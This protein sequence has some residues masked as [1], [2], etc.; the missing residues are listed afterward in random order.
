MPI[1]CEIITQE[2][3]VF[4]DDVDIVIA[5]SVEGEMGIL[6]NHSPMIV[7]L[8]YGE[9]RTRKGNITEAFAIG[10]GVLQVTGERVIVLADS[11]E[12]AEEIDI[13]RAQAARE[14]A[15]RL[16]EE[17]VPED[18]AAYAQ[19]EAAIRRAE[20]RI[21]VARRV[22]GRRGTGPGA[23]EFGRPEPSESE[24]SGA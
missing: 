20:V 4:D 22:G 12:E 13:A 1:H 7:A 23:M 3:K 15:A 10:G 11:A 21:K 9:L 17:G 18:P 16:M 14:R 8:D 2:H 24:E 19:L 5:P 6:P